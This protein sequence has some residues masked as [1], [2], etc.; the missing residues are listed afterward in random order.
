MTLRF[1]VPR[2]NSRLISAPSAERALSASEYRSHILENDLLHVFVTVVDQ[3]G[4]T[5]AART[6][7]RTQAAV[8]L[9]I[10]RLEDAV[11]V[12]LIMRPQRSFRLTSEGEV[13]L[14]YARRLLALNAEA[15]RTLRAE[16]TECTIRVGSIDNYVANVLPPFV[17]AFCREHPKVNVELHG[18]MPSAMLSRIGTQFDVVIAMEPAG[19]S[20]GQVLRREPVVWATSF[21][22]RQHLRRPLPLALAP[23]GGMFR[24]WAIAALQQCGAPWRL[25][26]V[27][28]NI[29]GVEAAVREGLGVGVF[30][31]STIADRLRRLSEEDGFPRL[32][33][34]DIAIYSVAAPSSPAAL[35]RDHIAERLRDEAFNHTS[36]HSPE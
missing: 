32:P 30:K 1:R 31:A 8:S 11:G 7:H 22:H 4:F 13:L 21:E 27:N 2:Q 10:K 18:G 25:V 23:P 28:S 17:A 33:D 14:D 15:I 5:A 36:A 9:Q 6:L 35:L 26:Y 34:V 19:T 29:A 16:E 3:G 20:Q 12:S 24:H